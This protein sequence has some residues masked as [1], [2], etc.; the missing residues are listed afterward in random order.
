[1]S[2]ACAIVAL[3]TP[4]AISS[5]LMR[6]RPMPLR[7]RV[8]TKAAAK[9]ESSSHF[10]RRSRSMAAS[11]ASCGNSFRSSLRAQLRLA[12]EAMV[13]DAQSGRVAAFDVVR[14]AQSLRSTPPRSDA[15]HGR[16]ILPYLCS[17]RLRPTSSRAGI[18]RCLHPSNFS[19]STNRR[20]HAFDTP[21]LSPSPHRRGCGTLSPHRVRRQ[22]GTA[23]RA[24]SSR[25]P[26]RSNGIRRSIAAATLLS[27]QRPDGE[28]ITETFAAGRNPMLRL[29]GLADGIYSYELRIA[30]ADSAPLVQSGSFTV[31]NGAIVSPGRG[32][33][34]AHWTASAAGAEHV[35]HRLRLR[36]RRRLRRCRLHEHRDRLG[37]PRP[38]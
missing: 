29:D 21:V 15:A 23:T 9:R 10:S 38:S 7:R 24:R 34:R 26:E 19:L 11:I 14:H 8:R 37:S 13:E 27:V 4:A 12:V 22:C 20:Q 3:S 31:A 33:A 6:S 5:R 36:R 32:R 2:S 28:V 16:A 25:P 35:L 18:E 1:M 30:Q 17:S